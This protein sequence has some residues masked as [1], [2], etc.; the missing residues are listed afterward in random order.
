MKV[1]F[2]FLDTS[3]VIRER[4]FV[5]FFT[6]CHLKFLAILWHY[7]MMCLAKFDTD[8]VLNVPNPL[9][10]QQTTHLYTHKVFRP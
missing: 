1:D 10:F 8:E 6:P 4:I 7:S 2:I 3:V 9:I 5:V